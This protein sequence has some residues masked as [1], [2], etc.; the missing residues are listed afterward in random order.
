MGPVEDRAHSQLTQRVDALE[1][2]DIVKRL[3]DLEAAKFSELADHGFEQS[4][5]ED[6]SLVQRIRHLEGWRSY[7]ETNGVRVDTSPIEERLQRCETF[8]HTI[9]EAPDDIDPIVERI[10][11]LEKWYC[12]ADSPKT[13]ATGISYEAKS[14]IPDSDTTIDPG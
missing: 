7:L 6:N 12:R 5:V 13:S 8:Q 2:A 3:A 11:Q 14:S 1:K 9:E 4:A 10:E